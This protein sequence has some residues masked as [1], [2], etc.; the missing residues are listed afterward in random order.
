M[1][2]VDEINSEKSIFF[3]GHIRCAGGIKYAKNIKAG[4]GIE[5]GADFGIYAG[6]SVRISRKADFATIKAKE[7]PRN[8]VCGT[9]VKAEE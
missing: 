9:F 2:E 6:L 3:S 1:L 7:E 8:I 5:A 4:C